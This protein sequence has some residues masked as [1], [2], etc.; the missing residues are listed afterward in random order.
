M[1]IWKIHSSSRRLDY[2]VSDEILISIDRVRNL[3]G[4]M[5]LMAT[6]Q[7]PCTSVPGD[8]SNRFPC[9]GQFRL[10]KAGDQVW[11]IDIT[12][13]PLRKRL[14]LPGGDR[15]SLLLERLLLQL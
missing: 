1:F 8:L 2:L 6:Y 11:A 10:A 12:Q 14:S 4:R 13:V 9:L 5:G 15:R 3:I 7:K